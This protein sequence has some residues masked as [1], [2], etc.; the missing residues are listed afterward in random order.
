MLLFIFLIFS[1]CVLTSVTAL[2]SKK[3][4]SFLTWADYID[5]D[6]IRSFEAEFNIKVKEVYFETD[7]EREQKLAYTSGEGY[8][9]ILVSGPYIASHSK[10]NWISPLDLS[11]IPNIE[12][13]DDRWRNAYPKAE[14]YAVPYLWGAIG[15]AYRTDLMSEKIV[16]WKQFFEP[17]P[18]LSGKIGMI[19]DSKE[20]I[21]M[22]LKSF[23]YSINSENSMELEKVE[24]LLLSQKPF[25]REYSTPNLTKKSPMV[26][27][28]MW[29]RMTYNGD[30][31]MLQEYSSKIEFVV[32]KEGTGLWVDYLTIP[33]SSKKKDS[34]MAFINFLNSPKNAARLAAY[35]Y[36]ATPNKSAENFLPPDHLTN[37]VIYPPKEVLDRSEFFKK[38]PP[39]IE[40][41][42]NLIF[43]KVTR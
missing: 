11:Q 16:S 31:L 20:V 13:I 32:P 36:Y 12:H 39:K 37:P 2:T 19:N 9:L 1:I 5:P 29:M 7:E 30:A 42:R 10:R 43:L 40:R 41:K 28:E 33:Q 25:V 3:T 27:G 35:V 4:I 38:L 18:S 26:S 23:E 15:I 34:A 22:A 14:T 17:H 6:L 24:Q 8:D 21:G